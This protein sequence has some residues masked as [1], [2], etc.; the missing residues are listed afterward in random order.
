MSL[1]KKTEDRK[2]HKTV[3]IGLD[4]VPFTF[5]KKLIEKNKL[6]NISS[7]IKKGRFNKMSVCLPE[8]S[9]VSWSSFMTGAQSGEHGIFGFVDLIPGS[10]KMYFPNFSNLKLNTIFDDLGEMS[11]RS[12]VI[13]LPSTYPS[14]NIS[15]VLISGFVAPNLKK[16]V[17]PSN[18]FKELQKIKY[19]IDIDTK[20][21]RSDTGFLFR[22]LDTT[23][24][25]RMAIGEFLWNRE[26]WD[27]FLIVVTG[28]DRIN[29]FLWNS[30]S[31]PSKKLHKDFIQY[32]QKVDKFVGTFF[33]KFMELPGSNI[34][35]NHFMILSDH[36]FTGIESEIY[37]NKWLEENGFLSYINNHPSSWEDINP[38]SKA[39]A[40]DPSRIYINKKDRFKNGSIGKKDVEKIKSEIASGL[41]EL[42]YKNGSPVLRQ[43]FDREQLYH[44]PYK[45]F[46]PDLVLLSEY[47]FDLK[48]KI[49]SPYLFGRSNLQGMH[50]N[51]DAFIFSNRGN[52]V[53]TIFDVKNLILDEYHKT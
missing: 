29:H 12:I 20:R 24:K 36:G 41:G 31:D 40:M 14:R 38:S 8:I 32:Y 1:F 7:I 6:P 9:S 11:K 4:G 51:D 5:L 50:T 10:Y 33:T 34:G 2:R 13:N 26:Q 37:I 21:S 42:T 49:G 15:G 53:R 28:T 22:S 27:L 43:V 45:K 35:K 23:L 18:L 46:G 17:Y 47:G 16:A 3:I 25:S 52:G 19:S 44:G 48:G 39:F 30:G